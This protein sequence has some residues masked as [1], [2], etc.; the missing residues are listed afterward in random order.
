MKQNDKDLLMFPR[1]AKLQ[2]SRYWGVAVAEEDVAKDTSKAQIIKEIK[3]I[4]EGRDNRG[5]VVTMT[6]TPQSAR[7]YSKYPEKKIVRVWLVRCFLCNT[8]TKAMHTKMYHNKRPTV[9][10]RKSEWST[11]STYCALMPTWM[12]VKITAHFHLLWDIVSNCWHAF[13]FCC[14]IWLL[15]FSNCLSVGFKLWNNHWSSRKKIWSLSCNQWWSARWP[16]F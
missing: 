7:E 5:D 6:A 1:I 13:Q 3:H 2:D 10:R 4:I 8:K 9:S 16:N 14:L 11:S 12:L 15:P